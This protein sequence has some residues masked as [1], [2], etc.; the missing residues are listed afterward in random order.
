MRYEKQFCRIEEDEGRL[1]E[2]RR[3]FEAILRGLVRDGD[4][5]LPRADLMELILRADDG[6][7]RGAR[8]GR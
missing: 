5:E 2:L 8:A 7:C 4:E 1:A 3:E 6:L